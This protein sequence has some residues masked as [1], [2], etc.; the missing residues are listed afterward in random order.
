VVVLVLAGVLTRSVISLND[1]D[2]GFDDRGLIS[3][4][5]ALP[6]ASYQ[7]PEQIAAFRDRVLE[8]L[9]RVPGV[10]ARAVSSALP[11]GVAQ[12]AVVS[13][14]GSVSPTDYR[15]AAIHAVTADYATTLAVA[16]TAGRFF[17]PTDAPHTRVAVLNATLARSLWPDGD[18][19]GR[20]ISLVGESAPLTIVGVVGDV[21]QA[22]PQ[23]PAAPAIYRL[24]SQTEQRVNNLHFLL[25]SDVPLARLG[26][27]VRHAVASVDPEIPVF[28]LRTVADSVA[29]TTAVQ[30]F[31]MLVVGV[32]AAFAMVLALSGLY[33]VLA[34]TVQ[35]ARRDFGI[36]QALGATRA[37]I[38][39]VVLSQALW[40]AVIGIGAGAIAALAASEL[41]AS[42]LFGVRPNDPATIVG[43]AAGI[44]AASLL[45]VLA[46]A[47][48]AARVDPATLLRHD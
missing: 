43:V 28:A 8:Q 25:R 9:D 15:P 16:V 38:I 47:V 12:P 24:L 30:R 45:A 44:L 17:D 19:V 18:V 6:E 26:D 23:R 42:L 13:P 5:V 3:F 10:R 41:I 40:P 37:R 31:N 39:R 11:V 4:S 36:R 35:R 32:F 21:R 20:S 46:P 1:V 22:G 33:A 27:G 29:A 48:R 34:H 7:R 14:A 2:S